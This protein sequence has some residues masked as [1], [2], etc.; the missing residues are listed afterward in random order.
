[1]TSHA[2]IVAIIV[3]YHPDIASLE[4]LVESL[5][6]QVGRV[7][8]VDNGSPDARARLAPVTADVLYLDDNHGVATAQNRGL[9][10]AAEQGAEYALLMDQDSRPAP[11]MVPRLTAALERLQGRGEAVAAVGP[12]YGDA[13]VDHRSPFHRMRGLRLERPSCDEADGLVEVDHLTASGCLIPLAVL[14][15]VGP[16]DDALFIDYVDVEWGLRARHAGYGLYGVCGAHMSHPLGGAPINFLGRRF[17]SHAP[18]RNYY[19]FRN[20]LLLM[21]RGYVPWNWKLVEARRLVLRLA[22]YM[23]AAPGRLRHLRM[24]GMGVAH[25]V[26][27][28]SGPLK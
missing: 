27:R 14:A 28:R 17:V 21:R 2:A 15:Q 4:R 1:M 16:M 19:Y 20:A 3:T 11:D 24:I 9:A 10:R 23:A 18:F 6:R 8:V 26:L 7:L 12:E 13:R 25:G 5:G 22:L